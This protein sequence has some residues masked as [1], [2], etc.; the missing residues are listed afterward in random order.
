[1]VL[2]TIQLP[3]FPVIRADE[4]IGLETLIVPCLIIGRVRDDLGEGYIRVFEGTTISYCCQNYS[5]QIVI[6]KNTNLAW[7][8]SEYLSRS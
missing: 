5:L 7:L 1:M 6:G 3:F 4:H 2:K 8:T